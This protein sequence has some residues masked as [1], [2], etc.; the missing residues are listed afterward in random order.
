MLTGSDS[1]GSEHLWF[2]ILAA[3]KKLHGSGTERLFLLGPSEISIH[4]RCR[5]INVDAPGVAL[6]N[7][8]HA[9]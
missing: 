9:L 7:S 2:P 6:Q 8:A 3:K 5:R 1:R 4:L